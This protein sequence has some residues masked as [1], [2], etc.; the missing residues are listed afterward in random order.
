[1]LDKICQLARDAQ[2]DDDLLWLLSSSFS[3]IVLV[4]YFIYSRRVP[5]VFSR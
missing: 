4:P 5:I 2:S 3:L 1:M